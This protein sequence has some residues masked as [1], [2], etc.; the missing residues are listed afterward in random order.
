MLPFPI[1]SWKEGTQVPADAPWRSPCSPRKLV[2]KARGPSIMG[3]FVEQRATVKPSSH[4]A[5]LT[6]KGCCFCKEFLNLI[7]YFNEWT[8]KLG[9]RLQNSLYEDTTVKV[10]HLFTHFQK[11]LICPCSV[12]QTFNSQKVSKTDRGCKYTMRTTQNHSIQRMCNVFYT[13]HN[14]VELGDW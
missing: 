10:M 11:W 12:Q 5:V 4:I 1:G 6:S 3:P 9:S 8:V 13:Y 2:L 7:L 14:V